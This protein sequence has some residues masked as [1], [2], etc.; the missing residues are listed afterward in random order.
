MGRA[1]VGRQVA[2]RPDVIIVPQREGES[3]L[4]VI[5][6]GAFSLR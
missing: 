6:C 1:F 5:E 3:R 2:L 4:E